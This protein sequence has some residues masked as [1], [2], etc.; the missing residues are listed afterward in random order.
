MSKTENMAAEL[1]DQLMAEASTGD[2]QKIKTAIVMLVEYSAF[3]MARH[4]GANAAGPLFDLAK[5][6]EDRFNG[7]A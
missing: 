4:H 7:A 1:C 5:D 2:L 3:E 6:F